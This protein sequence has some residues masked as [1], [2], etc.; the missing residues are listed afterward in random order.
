M[1]CGMIHAKNKRIGWMT[2]V[3]LVWTAV[4]LLCALASADLP[5]H[6]AEIAT[7]SHTSS[8]VPCPRC[9]K[10][11]TIVETQKSTCT[12]RGYT[13]YNCDECNQYHEI[14]YEELVPHSMRQIS[15]VAP[16]CD[17]S[18]YTIHKCTVCGVTEQ[19]EDAQPLGHEY[20]EEVI[21]PTCSSIGYTLHT[22]SRCADSYQTEQV[23]TIP[24]T[25]EKT[26]IL[27]ATCHSV[28][29]MQC[30]CTVCGYRST[31]AIPAVDHDWATQSVAA[32][33]TEQGYTV[34]TCR[35]E[36]CNT[37]M[38]GNFT[39]L[40]PYDM[41]WSEQAATCTESG[42]RFG[43]CSDGC[44]HTE[45]EVIPNLEHAY[46]DW[47]TLRQADEFADGLESHVCNRCGH[48]ET[49]P[50]IYDPDAIET[51]PT[52]PMTWLIILFLTVL[53]V[54]L[55]LLCFLLLMEHARRDTS[56]QKIKRK[57]ELG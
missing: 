55:I 23:G 31:E 50:I 13:E 5:V 20:R 27:A 8:S 56:K 46:D 16:T 35:Y 15:T 37:V 9:K 32:T 42:M 39:D 7:A 43:Y 48:T 3:L 57:R 51:K 11:L 30:N 28:G 22:C 18:G 33:H 40:L 1:G 53:G 36:G 6:A 54:G 21:A 2:A 25:Y 26:E 24:H 44:G 52:H 14:F 4:L 45:T 17:T 47:M 34:Y 19:K 49:R 41:V 12:L 38:R 29:Q 10:P